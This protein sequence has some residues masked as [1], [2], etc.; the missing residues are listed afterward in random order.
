MRI[1]KIACG[2]HLVWFY[3]LQ[4]GDGFLD[5]VLPYRV[6][7]GFAAVVFGEPFLPT[8]SL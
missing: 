4:Q 5:I 7:L 3:G 2:E 1:G 6:P 8:L